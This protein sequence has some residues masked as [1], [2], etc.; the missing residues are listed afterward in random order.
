VEMASSPRELH[1][2]YRAAL[3]LNETLEKVAG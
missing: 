3:Y 2:R 1:A